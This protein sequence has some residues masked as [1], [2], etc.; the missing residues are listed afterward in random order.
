MLAVSRRQGGFLLPRELGYNAPQQRAPDLQGR[1]FPGRKRPP[2]EKY[3]RKCRLIHGPRLQIVGH[4]PGLKRFL[5]RSR[6]SFASLGESEHW[7]SKM[8]SAKIRVMEIPCLATP[9]QNPS[10]FEAK[11]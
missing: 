1:F 5:G 10:I 8:L 9:R 3:R 4:D 7:V 6:N 11:A 2:R